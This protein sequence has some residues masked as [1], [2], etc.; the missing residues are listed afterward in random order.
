[1]YV[2]CSCTALGSNPSLVTSELWDL[3]LQVDDD[4]GLEGLYEDEVT[5]G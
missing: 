2:L 4:I 1:M 3:S 5:V